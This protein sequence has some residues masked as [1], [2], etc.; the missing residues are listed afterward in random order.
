MSDSIIFRI[1]IDPQLSDDSQKHL[2]ETVQRALDEAIQ[3]ANADNEAEYKFDVKAEKPEV[4]GPF[5]G[6]GEAAIMLALLHVLKVGAI[7]AAKGGVGAAGAAFVNA[8]LVPKLRAWNIL[9]GDPQ[10][11]PA[12]QEQPAPPKAPVKPNSTA[13]TSSEDKDKENNDK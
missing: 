11:L 5:G 2:E 12:K 9:P 4:E 1:P 6:V 10:Q 7:A 3:E 8:Y 13:E